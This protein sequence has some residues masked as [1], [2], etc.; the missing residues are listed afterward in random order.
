[1]AFDSEHARGKRANRPEEHLHTWGRG[2][3]EHPTPLL[4]DLHAELEKIRKLMEEAIHEAIEDANAPRTRYKAR[5]GELRSARG[6]SYRYDFLLEKLWEAKDDTPVKIQIDPS[7]PKRVIDGTVIET[8]GTVIS[9]ATEIPLPEQALQLITLYEDT[10]WLLQKLLN[11][12][13][14]L[15]ETPYQMGAKTFG[16]VACIDGKLDKGKLLKKIGSFVPD[17]DQRK[18]LW[19]GLYCDTLRLIAPPGAGKTKTLTALAWNYMRS[20]MKVLLLAPTNGAVDNAVASLVELCKDTESSDWLSTHR[21]VRIGNARDLDAEVYRD[22]L[23]GSI[24]D[25][26]LG[27]LATVRDALKQENTQLSEEQARLEP[28]LVHKKKVWKSQRRPIAHHLEETEAKLGEVKVHIEEMRVSIEEEIKARQHECT[29]ARLTLGPLEIS[30]R[31]LSDRYREIERLQQAVRRELASVEREIAQVEEMN[32]LQRFLYVRQ[33]A[34]GGEEIA[35]RLQLLGYEIPGTYDLEEEK[36]YARRLREVIGSLG[37]TLQGLKKELDEI[38]F[39]KIEP[40]VIIE[41]ANQREAELRKIL[42]EHPNAY[43]R[44]LRAQHEQEHDRIAA[45]LSQGESEISTIEQR[46]EQIRDRRNEIRE[47]L[48]EIE[49]E[50]RLVKEQVAANAD[51]IATTLTGV[52][53]SPYLIGRYFD[54]VIIDE[55]SMAALPVILVAAARATQHVNIIGDPFQLAPITGLNDER[56]YPN[57]REW[58]GT[59]LFSYLEISLEQAERGEKQ[60]VFLSQQSRMDPDISLPVSKYIYQGRLKNRERPGY[61]RRALEP[62]PEKAWLVVD[63]SDEP[64]CQFK[65]PANRRSKYNEYH[66]RCDLQIVRRLLDSM[67]EAMRANHPYIGIITPYAPQARKIRAALFERGW[68]RFVRCGTIHA[69]QGREYVAVIVDFVEAPPEDKEEKPIIPRFTSDVWGHR[70]IATPATRLINVAHSRAREK[71]IY[72]ADVQYHRDHSSERHV[73]M[74]FINAGIESG[75]IASHELLQ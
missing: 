34:L 52:Y 9:L 4:I 72:V 67:P 55:A 31:Q 56:K 36:T 42:V 64:T 25:Q 33:R 1:M 47:R 65:R 29:T 16:V 27:E 70:G 74:Q 26:E 59:D 40:Q 2:W 73:L 50:S 63:T 46:I 28:E 66:I 7:D 69:V 6:A 10:S 49:R 57:A 24:A 30:E 8:D 5:N 58:L 21:I 60:T 45:E 20:G 38:Q 15:R 44:N 39:R 23:H 51:L 14:V 37:Q 12:V 43:Y 13:I 3:I 41:R 18:A 75:R 68:D 22:V 61:H 54:C 71:L 35:R 48:E 53:T 17:D 19:R 11:A 62:L 32:W